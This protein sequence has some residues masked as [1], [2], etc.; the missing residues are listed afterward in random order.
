MCLLA[1]RSTTALKFDQQ[2]RLPNILS[3]QFIKVLKLI[4][5]GNYLPSEARFF[6]QTL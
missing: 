4:F 3:N 2:N 5:C 6:P 1:F